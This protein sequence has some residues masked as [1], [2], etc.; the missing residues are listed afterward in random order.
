MARVLP[1]ALL[2]VTA[3]TALASS[4]GAQAN[5]DQASDAVLQQL[6]AFRRDDYE[7]A[8]SFASM[9]IHSIFDRRGFEAMVRRGYPEIAKCARA[10]VVD[11]KIA[12]DGHVFLKVKIVGVNGRHVEAVYELIWEQGAWKINGVVAQPDPGEE[13][14]RRAPRGAAAA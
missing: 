8:Y 7:R 5:P 2:L 3:L 14:S 11:R 1:A 4:A 12:P 9:E 13:A 10:R 6:D